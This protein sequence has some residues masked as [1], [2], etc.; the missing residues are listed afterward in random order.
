MPYFTVS[1]RR[2][3]T[4]VVTPLRSLTASPSQI[5]GLNVADVRFPRLSPPSQVYS[6]VIAD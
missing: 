1:E 6:F 2:A 5:H 3:N 4:L